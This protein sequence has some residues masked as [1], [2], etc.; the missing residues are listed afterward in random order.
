MFVP[1]NEAW[2]RFFNTPIREF[3]A[4]NTLP[5]DGR[6]L[7]DVSDRNLRSAASGD[8][9]A[10]LKELGIDIETTN[11]TTP[12]KFLFD[13]ST[14]PE[15]SVLEEEI[16]LAHVIDEKKVLF[17]DLTCGAVFNMADEKVET[18]TEC[19]KRVLAQEKFQ[20]AS[21]NIAS[22]DLR[23]K[24]LEQRSDIMA[25]NG[26]IHAIDFVIFPN[27]WDPKLPDPS[28]S[29]SMAPSTSLMPSRE[30]SMMPSRE[31]SSA[32]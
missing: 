10:Y 3:L 19:S 9:V 29:P 22:K 7:S 1:V 2:S 27:F 32:D 18:K 25:K 13:L 26:V 12:V 17:E 30:P 5:R 6:F 14:N 16:L 31:P 11:T 20:V 4:G 15:G 8:V 21:W 23:P 28:T 24:I